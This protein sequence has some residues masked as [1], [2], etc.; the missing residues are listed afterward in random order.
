MLSV[1][2]EL[3][4]ISDKEFKKVFELSIEISKLI[5]GLIKTL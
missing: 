2:L 4:Y 5:S 1:A 3:N